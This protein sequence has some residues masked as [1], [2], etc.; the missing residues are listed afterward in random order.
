MLKLLPGPVVEETQPLPPGLEKPR[1]LHREDE[2]LDTN[3]SEMTT[4]WTGQYV[5]T[6]I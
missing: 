6:V 5:K 2:I 4:Q 1:K 3:Q